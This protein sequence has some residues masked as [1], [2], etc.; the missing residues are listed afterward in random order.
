MT[1]EAGKHSD[2][3]KKIQTIIGD[4]TSLFWKK[5][6]SNDENI[7]CT[8]V[9]KVENLFKDRHLLEKK[10]FLNTKNYK[11]EKS[12]KIKTVIDKKI[13]NTKKN[14]KAP[15]LAEHNYIINKL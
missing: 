5:K 9:E 4:K 13:S 2:I 8:L 12:L 1:S 15:L 14:Q 7:C 6:F 10:I 3:I 11:K